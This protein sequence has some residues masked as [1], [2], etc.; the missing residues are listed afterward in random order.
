VTAASL[1]RQ[2]PERD[3][4]GKVAFREN[5]FVYSRMSN[6]T[7]TMNE[8]CLCSAVILVMSIQ[9][10]YRKHA[11]RCRSSPNV[12]LKRRIER[13][14]FCSHKIGNYWRR[15]PKPKPRLRMNSK[16][17]RSNVAGNAIRARV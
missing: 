16:V 13:F 11:D 4:N 10:E 17:P 15:T 8:Q 3:A 12:H 14:G 1:G 2:S 7:T 9:D 5:R 6:D